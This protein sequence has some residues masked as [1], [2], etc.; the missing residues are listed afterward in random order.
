MNKID[1]QSILSISS[2]LLF[3]NPIP[4][5][6]ALDKA[7]IDKA[8][9]QATDEASYSG[10][11][12]NANTPFILKRIKELTQGAS[13]TAN[14]LLVENNVIRGTKV[15]MELSKLYQDKGHQIEG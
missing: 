10:I 13:T 2:G 7:D 14:R 5:R 11:Q 3:A 8:I 15:A 6:A 9:K 1:A 12:G 4:S